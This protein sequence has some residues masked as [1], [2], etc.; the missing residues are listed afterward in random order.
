MGERFEQP[1]QQ[2]QERFNATG[3]NGRDCPV[4]YRV[5]ALKG[6]REGDRPLL[7]CGGCRKLFRIIER[8]GGIVPDT[9]ER[10]RLENHPPFASNA[11]IQERL[12]TWDGAMPGGNACRCGAR[13]DGLGSTCGSCSRAIQS[14]AG[15]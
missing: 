5:G 11:E 9:L 8:G 2:R 10:V 14:E 4:C 15:R 13:L 12:E 7:E 3:I 1:G 6:A